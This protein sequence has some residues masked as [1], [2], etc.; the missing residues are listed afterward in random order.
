MPATSESLP[1]T[2][3]PTPTPTP[4]AAAPAPAWP[5]H[6]DV[7]VI[8]AG[9]AG[10]ACAQ[11]LAAAGIDVLLVDQHTFPRD[12]ICGDGLIPD[13]HA[14]LRTLGVYDELAALWQPAQ[15]VRCVGPRG[16]H[17]DVPGTVS[18]L[19]RRVLDEVLVRAAQRAGARLLA[20]LRF[21]SPLEDAQGR[22]AGARLR[23]GG[24][25]G[26][27][28]ERTHEV[29][30]RWVVLATGAVPQALTAAGMCERHTPSGVALR[31]YVR[32]PGLASSIRQ[33]QFIWHPRMRG[34]YGWIFPCRD[35][36]FNIGA[37]HPGSH[38]KL[39]SGKGRMQDLNLRRFFESFAE[40]YEPARRL[41]SEGE[42]LG[43]LKGAPLR[44]S[45]LG[46]RW[47]R[48]GLLVTGEAAGST[49]AFSGEGIGKAL[50]T[51]LLAADALLAAA[52]PQGRAAGLDAD[53]RQQYESSL[54]GLKPKF[55]LYERASR[56]NNH[57]W[58]ADLVIWRANKSPRIMA[59]MSAVIEERQNPGWLLSL[60]GMRKLLT[61]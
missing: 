50:E 13:A 22:V 43:E 1:P 51:G 59:R 8:G 58:L 6:C 26:G 25:G 57:P 49:Y 27:G 23:H 18:V 52:R 37:G 38:L 33:L 3:T 32:H 9:P 39:K 54:L 44:C 11:R 61:E 41:M 12:K 2:P 45:L 40:V 34:G 5:E 14:A 42:R 17:C 60:R 55:D 21:E 16:K 29:R 48:D 15:H 20:P 36:V 47:S 31:T 10:S 19:P 56:V 46:A 35:G 7:L 53:I 30:A 28:G 24:G 4:G